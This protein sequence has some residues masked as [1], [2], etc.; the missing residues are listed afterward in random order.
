VVE[1]SGVFS[2]C[3]SMSKKTH[4]NDTMMKSM[5]IIFINLFI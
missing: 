2:A 3:G 4:T 1:G 5:A